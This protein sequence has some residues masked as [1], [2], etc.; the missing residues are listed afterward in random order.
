MAEFSVAREFGRVFSTTVQGSDTAPS[1]LAVSVH[2][3]LAVVGNGMLL[4]LYNVDVG[5]EGTG[6]G[7]GV[8]YEDRISL[9]DC[10]QDDDGPELGAVVALAFSPGGVLYIGT[11]TG[12]VLSFRIL[13]RVLTGQAPGVNP[14]F[15]QRLMQVHLATG[16][17]V[18]HLLPSPRDED[19][20]LVGLTLPPEASAE[21]SLYTVYHDTG[22]ITFAPV[23]LQPSPTTALAFSPAAA[24]VASSDTNGVLRLWA[25]DLSDP[26][27]QDGPRH[28]RS[29]SLALLR[30]WRD[31]GGEPAH[32]LTWLTEPVL[33]PL[34]SEGEGNGGDAAILMSGHADGSV[35]VWSASGVPLCSYPQLHVRGKD[36]TVLS[37][38]VPIVGRSWFAPRA[39]PQNDTVSKYLLEKGVD[40]SIL[41]P[42]GLDFEP[43]HVVFS[44][45]SGS[46]TLRMWPLRHDGIPFPLDEA[47]KLESISV[48]G[49]QPRGFWVSPRSSVEDPIIVFVLT[50][51]G[52]NMLTFQAEG[53]ATDGGDVGDAGGEGGEVSEFGDE[54]VQAALAT[55]A[56]QRVPPP[57]SS[58]L[59]RDS[60]VDPG[61]GVDGEE[62]NRG[63]KDAHTL[64]AL[65]PV[66]ERKTYPARRPTDTKGR[67]QDLAHRVGTLENELTLVR[68]SFTVFSDA[69]TRDM[70]RI[71][72]LI[73]D[74]APPPTSAASASTGADPSHAHHSYS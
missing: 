30:E 41:A 45:S 33:P 66:G 64:Y 72:S 65:P 18:S 39:T 3:G 51:D 28:A 20:V 10:G 59:A 24:H 23:L 1:V 52:L 37:G 42:F 6:G 22:T 44:L 14:L 50:N 7:R 54:A 2:L 16:A 5:G 57:Q 53:G 27:D 62:G 13:K 15:A 26:G 25:V 49:I 12:H 11:A 19:M 73:S 46:P 43:T 60:G 9:L 63:A 71:L 32:A 38:L 74:L 69:M 34:V 8:T 68:N 55:S 56:A 48:S 67:L 21:S 4:D 35:K 47:L 40:P 70:A 31:P 29:M 36:I 58:S 17:Y 61:N